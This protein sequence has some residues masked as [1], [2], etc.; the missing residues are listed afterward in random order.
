MTARGFWVTLAASA[1]LGMAMAWL[2]AA[3][4]LGTV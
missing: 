2:S 3:V 4:F 1:C